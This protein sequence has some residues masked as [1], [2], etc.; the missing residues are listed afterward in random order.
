MPGVDGLEVLSSAKRAEPARPVIVMT[1]FSAIDS[2]IES[3]RRGAHH[4]LTKPFKADELALFLERAL[5][6]VRL[7]EETASLR[8]ALYDRFLH[9]GTSSA[10]ARRMREVVDVIDRV[11]KTSVA[12][13]ILGETGTGKGV[14]AR[15]IH[16][17][18]P[19]AKGPFIGVNCA[20]LPDSLLE[21]ELFGHAKGAF[22]GA[23][24]AR[25]GLFTDAH[26]GT[27]LLDEIG[28]MSPALQA[29]LSTSSRATSSRPVGGSKEHAVERCE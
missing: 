4:Y 14:V 25:S 21:S 27:L 24:Q 9:S 3:I 18:S 2:A 17:E 16:A 12:V 28:E 13:L 10:R 23:T 1:A 26:G 22:T 20:A 11:A 5:D 6:E 29:K 8:R 19:R 15:A 7:R